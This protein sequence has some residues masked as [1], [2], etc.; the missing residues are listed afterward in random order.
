MKTADGDDPTLALAIANSAVDDESKRN[1][2]S[3]SSLALTSELL[4]PNTAGPSS[5][6]YRVVFDDPMRRK[7]MKYGYAFGTPYSLRLPHN[8]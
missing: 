1:E 5:A 6:D 2:T 4:L 7:V 8:I 3:G